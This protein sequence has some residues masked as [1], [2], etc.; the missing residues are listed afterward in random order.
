MRS[1]GVSRQVRRKSGSI[2]ARVASNALQRID[3]PTRRRIASALDAERDQLVDAWERRHRSEP[4][5]AEPVIAQLG[6]WDVY[7]RAY[8]KPLVGT[9]ARGLR[10]GRSEHLDVYA[11][12]RMRFMA[13]RDLRDGGTA[14]LARTLAG[15]LDDA[16]T[17]FTGRPGDAEVVRS[18]LQPI[19]DALLEE[20]DD[21]TVR[22]VM[23]GDCLLTDVSS[24]LGPRAREN[25]VQVRSELLYFS[26]W[27]GRELS[28]EELL[29]TL[30][31]ESWD[32]IGLS[33]FT[34]EGIPPYVALLSEADGLSS[35]ERA[36][37]VDQIDAIARE[38]VQAVRQATN[39]PIILH[40][41]CGLPLTRPREFVPVLPPLSRGRRHVAWLLNERMG[42][43]AENTENAIFLDE[44]AAVSEVGP[45]AAGRR[46]LP[47]R[48]THG[49]LFHP[50]M[51]GRLLADGYT[52]IVRA[53]EGLR[54]CKV[55]LVDFDNTL[56]EGV[57]AEGT[58]VHDERGQRL[59]GQ[60]REAGILLVSVSK[61]DPDSIRW[62]EMSVDR[63]DFVLHKVSWN[64]KSQ[65]IEEAA[66]QLDLGLDSFVL[67]DDNPVERDLVSSA[68]PAVRT[69][70]PTDPW[71]WRA[72]EMLL[73]FPNTRRTAEAARRTEMYREGAERRDALS[74]GA[75]YAGMMRSLDLRVRFG[76]VREEHLDRVSELVARTNQFN[77][78]TV[79]RNRAELTSIMQ[80][81]DAALLAGTLSDKFGDL[82]IVGV[83][84]VHKDDSELVFDGV[85]MSCR[86]MGFGFESVLVRGA[87]DAVPGV[88]TALGLFVPT[89]RN[90]PCARLFAELGFQ[91]C[92]EGR[93][94]LALD[95]EL[96][97]IPDWLA[98]SAL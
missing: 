49:G 22:V 91:D 6:D 46:L 2:F 73:H 42:E 40:G 3:A 51:V 54:R 10:E 57:M 50:T 80:A 70:D 1:A 96:P 71:T 55:L 68:L 95:G 62:D 84:I 8:L 39:I 21:R 44:Q 86:A 93:F 75:D 53:Y 18:L 24:F 11:Y 30:Q 65:S 25:G 35:G 47:R 92:G 5:L 60:L 89:D 9:L 29:E 94:W 85:I 63:N 4:L 66:H 79:R 67:I 81:P 27:A 82:G 78:T 33:F 38:Y 7:R 45:R 83:S 69:L 32:L 90:R 12:E 59:L 61:N 72:L 41:C 97:E 76:P 52:E 88:D 43:L 37:R 34:Y 26:A 20:S 48:L 98:V 87:I 15:D 74:G 16:A 17:L 56:W 13:L 36:R 14:T 19:H 77:T 31:R 64:L 23:V 28:R 58:V